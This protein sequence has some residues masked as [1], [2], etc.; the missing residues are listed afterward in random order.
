MNKRFLLL[1]VA[2][3]TLS[4]M[5]CWNPQKGDW[6]V[7]K[8]SVRLD[9]KVSGYYGDYLIGKQFYNC[10]SDDLEVMKIDEVFT[11]NVGGDKWLRVLSGNCAGWA[12][13]EKFEEYD[14]LKHK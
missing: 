4:L 12:P 1:L 10:K 5:A 2:I 7:S 11:E 3:L 9:T 13:I 14:P 6:V 8:G